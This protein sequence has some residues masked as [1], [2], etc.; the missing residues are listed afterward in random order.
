MHAAANFGTS[1]KPS[2]LQAVWTQITDVWT[3]FLFFLLL[4][5]FPRRFPDKHRL[6]SSQPDAI[7]V[8]PMKRVPRSNSQYLLRS[9]EGR[10]EN[11]EESAPATATPPNSKARHPSQ[12]L[13]DQRHVHLVEVKYCEDTRPKASSRPPSSST[14]AYVVIFQRS[15]LKSPSI[16]SC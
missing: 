15:Q 12:L 6:T 14:A 2:S 9:A 11:R 7:L 8:V 3:S 13:P 10:G 1:S 16:L 4:N 5:I